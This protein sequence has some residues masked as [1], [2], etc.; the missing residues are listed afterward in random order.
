MIA[1]IPPK[2][3]A[4]L[5][6]AVV[7]A[8]AVAWTTPQHVA[9]GQTAAG[10][11]DR[12]SLLGLLEAGEY[13]R[14]DAYLSRLQQGYVAGERPEAALETAFAAFASADPALQRWLNA[15]I[16]RRPRSFAAYLA[17]GTYYRH[18]GRIGLQNGA[19][20]SPAN[21]TR[22]AV[23]AFFSLARQDIGRALERQ[24]RLGLGY[25]GL[26]AIAMAH[27]AGLDADLWFREGIGADPGSPALWRAYLLSL[28]PW[29][30]PDRDPAALMAELDGRVRELREGGPGD[31]ALAALG[32]FHAYVTAELLRRQRRHGQADR[33]YREALA[34]GRDWVFLRGAG[35]NAIQ[36]AKPLAALAFF[37][38][39]L[40]LRPQDPRLLDSRAHAL[41]ALGNHE[42][43]FRD[44]RLAL[45]LDP[46]NPRILHGY[47]QALR[48]Q[49]RTAAARDAIADAAPFAQDS[50]SIRALRG[51]LLTDLGRPHEALA[52]LRFAVEH[53]P[54]SGE[55]WRAYAE[56]L[57]RAKDCDG[58][59]KALV[60]YQR[61]CANGT[62]CS[63]NDLMWAREALAGTRDPDICPVYGILGP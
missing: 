23:E 14:L 12:A 8:L 49:G 56:A 55:S 40:E 1:A 17:R 47:V 7:A 50:P 13:E 26:V 31:P 32:G 57:Y 16:E 24:P 28:Q 59:A 22:K 60:T 36:D 15:W 62:R 54:H 6:A 45:G 19:G 52:D 18:L 33:A 43:A 48:A 53:A 4:R 34:Q 41:V 44:W 58:A 5:A 46:G 9:L 29:R 30:R 42:A 63:D 39:A 27:D 3:R 35:I 11:R 10:A 20:H 38:E 21:G 2:A 51:A 61:L 37:D 25:A